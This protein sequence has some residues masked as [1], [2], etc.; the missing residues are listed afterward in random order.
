[1]GI[2]ALDTGSIAPS[3]CAR[4]MSI[5]RTLREGLAPFYARLTHQRRVQIR[6]R[7]RSFLDGFDDHGQ[8]SE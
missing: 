5:A 7:D 2:E 6:Q 4:D 3:H 1:M 8:N